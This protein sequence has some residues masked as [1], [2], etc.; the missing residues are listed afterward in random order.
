VR[1]GVLQDETMVHE[2]PGTKLAA[3]QSRALH[4][5]QRNIVR[6]RA[7][8]C[9]RVGG[10]IR[11]WVC[12]C[13]RGLGGGCE[14]WKRLGNNYRTIYMSHIRRIRYIRTAILAA[15]VSPGSYTRGARRD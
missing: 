4:N 12:V 14:T 15:R 9:V 5:A 7:R 10:W 3:R 13:V 1:I 6:E 2:M 11:G 8:V